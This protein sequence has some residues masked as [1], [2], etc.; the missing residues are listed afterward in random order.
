[1][2]SVGACACGD[3]VYRWT[4][5]VTEKLLLGNFNARIRG[6]YSVEDE[7]LPNTSLRLIMDPELLFIL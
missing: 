1:M 2:I 5:K 6:L 3:T 4:V 7:S